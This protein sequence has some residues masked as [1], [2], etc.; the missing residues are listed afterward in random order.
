MQTCGCPSRVQGT[1][2]YSSPD[3]NCCA[4]ASPEHTEQTI[5]QRFPEQDVDPGV[6]D[7]VNRCY[8]DGSQVIFGVIVHQEAVGKHLHLKEKHKFLL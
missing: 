7:G 2:T 4:A 5:K 1:C 3:W 8:T 6:E